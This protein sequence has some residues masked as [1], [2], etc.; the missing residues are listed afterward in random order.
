MRLVSARVDRSAAYK[1]GHPAS[2]CYPWP[3]RAAHP[4]E[5]F[6]P[7]RKDTDVPRRFEVSIGWSSWRAAESGCGTEQ[8]RAWASSGTATGS[9]LGRGPGRGGSGV[10]RVSDCRGMA[11]H[12]TRRYRGRQDVRGCG[13]V[14][15]QP[16]RALPVLTWLGGSSASTSRASWARSADPTSSRG[17][18]LGPC[19][20]PSSSA[21]SPRRTGHQRAAD[22]H[23]TG[24]KCEVI[25]G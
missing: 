23:E 20:T 3:P 25:A 21:R 1:V 14:E 4:R 13:A 12:V 15:P 5:L 6:R 24:G 19:A 11:R 22:P 16:W 7:G 18:N 10:R 8:T 9:Y 2:V 17:T